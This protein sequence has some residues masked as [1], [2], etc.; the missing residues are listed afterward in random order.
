MSYL[1]FGYM[2]VG[3]CYARATWIAVSTD[4]SNKGLMADL[5]KK[6]IL[7]KAI[8]ISPAAV[9]ALLWPVPVLTKL[10]GLLLAARCRW[11]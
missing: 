4:P 3:A 6:G 11:R 1:I 7:L 9:L 5:D 8:A 10:F 2:L